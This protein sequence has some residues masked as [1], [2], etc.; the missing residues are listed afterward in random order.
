MNTVV[1]PKS[2]FPPHPEGLHDGRISGVEDK[3][4]IQTK[5]GLKHKI[6]V[7]IQSDTA[8]F[9]EDGRPSVASKWYTASSRS[10]SALLEFRETMAGRKLTRDERECLNPD[11]ELVGRAVGYTVIHNDGSEGRVYANITNIWPLNWEK[12]KAESVPAEGKDSFPNT[13]EAAMAMVCAKAKA[14]QMANVAWLK[15]RLESRGKNALDATVEDWREL[16][17]CVEPDLPF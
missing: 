2:E 7:H 16:W 5:S 14:N 12:A 13:P 1:I 9:L 8:V 10:K 6:V 4:E 11:T 15:G 3:G 17:G